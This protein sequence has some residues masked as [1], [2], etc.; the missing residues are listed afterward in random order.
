M[1]EEKGRRNEKKRVEGRKGLS[2]REKEKEV[3]EKWEEEE[4]KK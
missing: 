1:E 3:E 4:N 2:S